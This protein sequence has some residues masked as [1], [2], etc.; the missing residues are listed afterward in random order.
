MINRIFTI[1]CTVL[2]GVSGI[3]SAQQNKPDSTK[4]GHVITID[5]TSSNL[6]GTPARKPAKPTTGDLMLG[7]GKT[8]PKDLPP[9]QNKAQEYFNS[10]SQKG[11][12]GSF[13]GAIDDFTKSIQLAENTNAYMKRGYC[14]M[15]KEEFAKAIE[16]ENKA[17]DLDGRNAKALFVRGASK[18]ELSDPEGAEKDLEISV[19]SEHDNPMAYNYLA[20]TKFVKQDYKA[21]ADLYTQV[22][23]LDS[24]FPDAFSN[25][26]MMRHNLNDFQ[27][28]ISDYTMALKKNPR[29]SS[30]YNNRGAAK[31]MLKDFAGAKID[32]DA[33]LFM[34]PDYADAFNNRG[35]VKHYLGD[36]KGAC[37][38]WAKALELG[39]QDSQDMIQK[40]CK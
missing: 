20:A 36:D 7:T 34:N 19:A 6:K 14:Y 10:G 37:M 25:R 35:R 31:M 12:S 2:V 18:F 22:I 15:M 39:I 32:F 29:N 40:Y 3:A 23:K 33:A 17:L 28:A 8:Q 5:P 16:D 30:A 1:C 26:G 21:A 9:A 13:D 4:K 24:A 27:G 38:D 11:R